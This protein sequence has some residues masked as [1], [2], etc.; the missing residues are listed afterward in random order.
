M[1]YLYKNIIV[2][3]IVIMMIQCNYAMINNEKS[4]TTD[5][6]N[7]LLYLAFQRNYKA[8]FGT[9]EVSDQIKCDFEEVQ[10]HYSNYKLLDPNALLEINYLSEDGLNLLQKGGMATQI[11]AINNGVNKIHVHKRFDEIPSDQRKQAIAHEIAHFVLNKNPQLNPHCWVDKAFL[12]AMAGFYWASMGSTIPMLYYEKRK[13]E[14][15]LRCAQYGAGLFLGCLGVLGL[16]THIP[17]SDDYSSKCGIRYPFA[18]KYEEIMCDLVA[19]YIMPNGPAA[20]EQLYKTFRDYNG[21]RNGIHED[22][23]WTD[24][25]IKYHSFLKNLQKGLSCINN[26]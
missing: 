1:K 21:N 7:P 18:I 19:A 10:A 9:E 15:S 17:Q 3:L 25:R 4:H 6:S 13:P 26:K 24:T 2:I 14:R 22:H 8:L 11:N 16:W 5:S 20:G 23:P 12:S